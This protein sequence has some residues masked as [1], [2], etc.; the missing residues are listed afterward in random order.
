VSAILA[1]L[2]WSV[3]F[4]QT[5]QQTN[6]LRNKQRSIGLA[7]VTVSIQKLAASSSDLSNIVLSKLPVL[8]ATMYDSGF[9]TL[10]TLTSTFRTVFI[11]CASLLSYIA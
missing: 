6:K 10:S 5:S 3:V 7:A 8:E 1:D 2:R 4:R 9:S 11:C